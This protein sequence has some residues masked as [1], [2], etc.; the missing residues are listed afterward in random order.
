M[1]PRRLGN[2]DLWITPVGIGAWA[3]GGGSW[4]YGLGPQDDNESI[5]AIRRALD[6]GVNWIDTAPLYG[7]GHSEEVVGKALEGIA[8]KPFIFTK[9]SRVWDEH[10]RIYSSL[11]RDSIRREVEASLRRLRTEC[12][13]LYLMHWPCPAEELEEGWSAMAELKSE[14]TV[15][16]IGLSNCDVA[17]M[18][19]AQAIVPITFL[20]PPYSLLVRGVEAEIL[21]FAKANNIG[22][23]VYS[24]MRCG[25]LSGS[26]IRERVASLPEND[27]R[28]SMPDF[29]EP[30][31]STN[32]EFV[33]LLGRLA[34]RYGSTAG[35]A[36]VA[37]T[38]HQPAV[39]GAIVGVRRPE[40]VDAAVRA[41]S[42]HWSE[43]DLRQIEAFWNHNASSATTAEVAA[44]DYSVRTVPPPG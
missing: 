35:V 30:R 3:M 20:Q 25:L 11:R 12:I 43:A 33:R 9:C 10:G 42:Y 27:C 23:V 21:P 19:R 2:S 16:A 14:G 6:L 36:A 26:M 7:F 44:P 17:Q 1:R 39:T 41:V 22:V 18:R 40:Q 34:S 24:P 5:A 29:Q 8:A 15:R 28:R 32:L 4:K 37:W 13:D 31:L 38:L